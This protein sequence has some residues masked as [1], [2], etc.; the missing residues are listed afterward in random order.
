MKTLSLTLSH[1]F[2][3]PLFFSGRTTHD[4]KLLVGSPCINAGN[5]G[6]QFNDADGQ[7]F[8]R[9]AEIFSF[10]DCSF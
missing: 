1:L 10:I 3:M 6:V 7:D 2:W 9:L 8:A 4:Y 5:P